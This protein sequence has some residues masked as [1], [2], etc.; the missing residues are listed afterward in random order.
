[1]FLGAGMVSIPTADD[2][3]GKIQAFYDAHASIVI[4]AQAIGVIALIPLVLFVLAL[5]HGPADPSDHRRLIA[6]LMLVVITELATNV[7]PL[8]LSLLSSPS[9][10]TAHAWTLAGDV[11]D[12]ALFASL[13]LLALAAIPGNVA[14][15]RWAGVSV[16]LLALARAMG[17]PLGFTALDAIAP[18]AFLAFVLALSVQMLRSQPAM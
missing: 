4:V 18:I 7:S 11:A 13:G 16:A 14:W 8:V 9:G 2:P 6:A 12:A 3:S 15:L 1:L 5:A 17:S 10:S